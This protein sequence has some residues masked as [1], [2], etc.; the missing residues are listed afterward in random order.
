MAASRRRARAT[1]ARA[2]SV[3]W[4]ISSPSSSLSA[5][6]IAMSVYCL[7][8][9]SR[10]IRQR[11]SVR[12]HRNHS[13]APYVPTNSLRRRVKHERVLAREARPPLWSQLAPHDA[14]LQG[15]NPLVGVARVEVEDHVR[16]PRRADATG[17]GTFEQRLDV[18]AGI[19][20]A[21]GTVVDRLP[22]RTAHPGVIGRR[23]LE[24]VA[25]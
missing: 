24:V 12:V 18:G 3:A 22:L 21:P 17:D 1:A 15:M 25:V 16:Q 19:V 23:V 10:W 11:N 2:A 14:A 4:Y 13:P 8:A 20:E 9:G 6:V 5:G 7:L